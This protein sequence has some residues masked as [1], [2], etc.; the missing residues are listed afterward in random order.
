M[1]EAAVVAKQDANIPLAERKFHS[2]ENR[3]CDVKPLQINTRYNDVKTHLSA[4]Q[5][6]NAPGLVI[7]NKSFT[8]DAFA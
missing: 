3:N 7:E 1:H 6:V 2:K 5:A 4:V 8:A